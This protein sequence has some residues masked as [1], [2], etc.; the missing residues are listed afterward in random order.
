MN[1][2]EKKYLLKLARESIAN[3]FENKKTPIDALKS[4]LE[5]RGVFVTLTMDGRLRGCIGYLDAFK[6]LA[7]AVAENAANAA[8]RDP[9]FEPLGKEEIAKVK[10]EISVLTTPKKVSGHE[11]IRRGDGVIFELHSRSSTFLPQVWEELPEKEEF[12]S[13]LAAKAG[14]PSDAWKNR[15]AKFETYC[16]EKFSE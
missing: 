9:R 3:R 13:C 2:G 8:F 14:F 12:L 11:K 1:T 15:D 6:P 10:I 16:V 4:L 7:E 5:K